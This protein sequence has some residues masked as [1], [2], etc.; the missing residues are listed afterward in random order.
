MRNV[1]VNGSKKEQKEGATK[2][3]LFFGLILN[4]SWKYALFLSCHF[5]HLFLSIFWDRFY[6][7]LP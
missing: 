6:Q 4:I 3:I 1:E 7:N 5:N 2:L